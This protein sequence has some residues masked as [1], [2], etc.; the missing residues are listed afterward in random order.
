MV[1]FNNKI[2]KVSLVGMI[3]L[4]MAWFVREFNLPKVSINED[5]ARVQINFILPMDHDSFNEKIVILPDI[6]GTEFDCS[7]QWESS[8][9]VIIKIE[10]KS[11]IKGQKVHL[12]VKHAKTKLP[13]IKKSAN[14]PIQFQAVPKL[15]SI[16]KVAN[17]PTHDPIIV[18]FNTPM[19]RTNINKYIASDTE[20]EIMPVEG[21][22]NYKWRLT[23]KN[24]LENSK[25]YILSFRKGMPA[26]SGLTL[27]EDQVITLETASKAEIVGGL[28]Q[29]KERWV[30]LHPLVILE[31]KEALK[32]AI[33]EIDGKVVEGKIRDERWAEFILPKLLDFETTYDVRAQAVSVHGEHSDIYNFSFTTI[34]LEE[35]RLWVEV[36]LKEE[37]SVIVYK[38][39]EKIRLMPCSGGAPDS[40]TLLGTYFL[41]DRGSMFF[42]RKISE[43]ANNW[44]RISGNYLFH[45][46]PRDKDWVISK[47]AEAKIGY[48]ASHGCIR[49]REIDAKWFYDN[50]P[51]NTMVIIHE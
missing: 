1:T 16:N 20:F 44:V 4:I 36:I 45:G 21:G 19:K 14:I 26:V 7:T 31:S 18:K 47:E 17:I 38:G 39:R 27:E 13:Y 15:L 22:G 41:K 46:L 8:R 42:A 50:I 12:L 37:H 28:P 32:E 29:D 40:P 2:V 24:P 5:G 35:D 11:D 33:I 9:K 49:L 10:E 43:G 48:P 34:P 23:P 3:V 51:E 6:L 30:G 25:K